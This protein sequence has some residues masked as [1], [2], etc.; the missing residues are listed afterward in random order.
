[1]NNKVK[2]QVILLALAMLVLAVA[3]TPALAWFDEGTAGFQASTSMT[4]PAQYRAF[5][6]G[7]GDSGTPEY[8]LGLLQAEGW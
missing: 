4:T 5:A 7:A 2:R 3:A 6:G 1:M 8:P